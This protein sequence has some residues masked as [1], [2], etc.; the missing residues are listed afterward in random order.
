MKPPCSTDPLG[1]R[2][3]GSFFC[4]RGTECPACVPL[5]DQPGIILVSEKASPLRP[6]PD[7]LTG[8]WMNSRA[9]REGDDLL[10]PRSI[11]GL[12]NPLYATFE[13]IE[14]DIDL[15]CRSSQLFHDYASALL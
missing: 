2:L 15:D 3:S 4:R 7:V 10:E 9:P 1:Q 12:C 8:V 6:S 5:G 11:S 13:L 14:F